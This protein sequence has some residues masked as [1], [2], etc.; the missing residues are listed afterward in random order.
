MQA[1]ECLFTHFYF[2]QKAREKKKYILGDFVLAPGNS[3]FSIN[4]VEQQKEGMYSRFSGGNKYRFTNFSRENSE[5][6]CPGQLMYVSYFF[7]NST[8]M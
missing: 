2:T 3:P 5:Y 4:P 8:R 6:L 1:L 7:Y